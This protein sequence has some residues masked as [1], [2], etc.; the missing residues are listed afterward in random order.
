MSLGIEPASAPVLAAPTGV[1]CACWTLLCEVIVLGRLLHPPCRSPSPLTSDA[2][3]HQIPPNSPPQIPPLPPSNPAKQVA[4]ELLKEFDLQTL[5]TLSPLPGFA[6][7]VNHRLLVQARERSGTPEG[8]LAERLLVHLENDAWLSCH[9]AEAVVRP[10]LM[11]AAAVYLLWEKRRWA[12]RAR[13]V[14]GGVGETG[15][16]WLLAKPPGLLRGKAQHACTAGTAHMTLAGVQGEPAV[17]VVPEVLPQVV[18][19]PS[20]SHARHPAPTLPGVWRWTPWQR[21]T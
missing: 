18:R 21:S 15:D 10:W 4:T 11:R 12:L 6:A 5:V 2:S 13:V 16:A 1:L 7:W 14:S 8:D 19:P 20:A 3:H 17:C 9:E